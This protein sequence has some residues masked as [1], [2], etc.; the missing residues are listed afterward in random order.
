[1]PAAAPQAAIFCVTNGTELQNA[2]SSA[3]NNGQD[4]EVRIA[5]GTYVVPAAS[6]FVYDATQTGNDDLALTLSGGWTEFFGNPC[7]QQLATNNAFDT[8]I[9]GDNRF[10]ALIIR[11]RPDSDVTIRNLWF[12]RGQAP[13]AAGANQGGGLEIR[14]QSP[15]T[16]KFLIENCAF[17]SNQATNGSALSFLGGAEVRIRNS[18]FVANHALSSGALEVIAVSPGLYFTN[19]TVISNSSESGTLDAGARLQANA[20]GQYFIANN[21]FWNND[22]DDIQTNNPGTDTYFLN[23]DSQQ[24]TVP[25]TVQSGNVSITPQFDG[26]LLEFTPAEGSPLINAGVRPPSF[27][28]VPPP[29]HQAWST[30]TLDMNGNSRVRG[31]EIDMGAYEAPGPLL[32]DGF[33]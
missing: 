12:F 9:D 2:L 5:V 10:R 1:M 19:N 31:A 8:I 13:T 11:T 3:D 30:G 6:G 23:N 18:L 33:E 24:G 20:P 14:P 32:N 29:F 25:A 26:T 7:G 22:G 15:N 27:V 28:P 4:D 17:T 21:I 16:A